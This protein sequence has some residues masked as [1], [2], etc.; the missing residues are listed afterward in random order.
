VSRFSTE[1]TRLVA[2]IAALGNQT[3]ALAVDAA[4]TA[5]T[6]D[7]QGRTDAVVEQVCRLAVAAGVATG[8][9]AW[10]ANEL[11]QANAPQDQIDAAGTAVT[12][13]QSSLLN[14]AAAVQ[15][16]ADHGAPQEVFASADALRLSALRLDDLLPAYQPSARS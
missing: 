11:E 13:L 5:A 3:T 14:V 6:A 12:S 4:M 16:V 7:A 9:I 15:E 2:S 8:E 1:T 10:L